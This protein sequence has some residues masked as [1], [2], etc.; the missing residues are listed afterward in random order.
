ME[1]LEK[2]ALKKIMGGGGDGPCILSACVTYPPVCT[3]GG[4]P[5]FSNYCKTRN[6]AQYECCPKVGD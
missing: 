6:T 4:T 5:T 2:K 3:N 1:K